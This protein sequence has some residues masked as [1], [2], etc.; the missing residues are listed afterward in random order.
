MSRPGWLASDPCR[1]LASTGLDALADAADL[2]F[3]DVP[4][5]P[6][7]GKRALSV[8][9]QDAV[10]SDALAKFALDAIAS[11]EKLLVALGYEEDDAGS[12]GDGLADAG[13]SDEEPVSPQE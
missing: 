6:V 8:G 11:M 12:V 9:A 2:K 4:E 1:S 13:F 7:V 3:E 5:S 10:D